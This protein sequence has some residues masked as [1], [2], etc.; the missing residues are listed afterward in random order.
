MLREA[1]KRGLEA[2][3][4]DAG[5]EK[6][7]GLLSKVLTH[8]AT[9]GGVLGSGGS[10]I[11]DL[12]SGNTPSWKKALGAGAAGAT[13]GAGVRHGAPLLHRLAKKFPSVGKSMLTSSGQLAPGIAD[14][15]WLAPSL[16]AAPAMMA[17]AGGEGNNA[18]GKSHFRFRGKR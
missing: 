13:V 7:A 2:A 18:S 11:S 3:W 5:L 9:V 1:F 15:G 16:L 12:V 8:P 6:E 14:I 4:A 17:A 10:V